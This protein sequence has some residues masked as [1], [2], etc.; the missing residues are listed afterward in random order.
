MKLSP[1]M[2]ACLQDI[3][4]AGDAGYRD[5]RTGSQGRHWQQSYD[6]LRKRGLIVGSITKDERVYATNAGKA[7][8]A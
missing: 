5:E 2:L 7:V 1:R 4:A 3:V 6:G 8:A